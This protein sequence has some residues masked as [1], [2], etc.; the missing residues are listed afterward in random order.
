MERKK[1]ILV[2]EDDIGSRKLILLVLGAAYD[3]IEA[4]NGAEAID[5]AHASEPL[6]LIIIDLELPDVTG[7]TVIRQLK[8][9]PSTTHIPVF[10][11]TSSDQ[12]SLLVHRA[13]DA[14]AAKILYKPTPMNVLVAEVGQYLSQRAR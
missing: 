12:G 14:G 7:D 11:T 2:V 10:V 5:R 4:A 9:D 3:L 8:N 1:R 6:D 13:I